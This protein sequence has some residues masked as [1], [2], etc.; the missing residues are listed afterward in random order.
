[1]LGQGTKFLQQSHGHRRPND[2]LARLHPLDGVDQLGHAYVLEQIPLRAGF[3]RIEEIV[4]G[5]FETV[6]MITGM[7]GKRSPITR[8]A[9]GPDMTGMLRSISTM[10]G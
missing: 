6:S 5:V 3:D 1:M 8:T 9:S 2:G 10:S 7:A 4:V